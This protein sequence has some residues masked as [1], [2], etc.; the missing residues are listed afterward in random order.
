MMVMTER[1]TFSEKK[2][3]RFLSAESN[4]GPPSYKADVHPIAP[5]FL[6]CFIFHVAFIALQVSE[7]THIY[8]TLL[9][10]CTHTGSFITR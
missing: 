4:H 3:K 8:N 1:E 9:R 6:F 2:K 5:L 10:L 7:E